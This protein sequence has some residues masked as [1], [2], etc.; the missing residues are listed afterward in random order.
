MWC[1]QPS[2]SLDRQ[3]RHFYFRL[4]PPPR[5]HPISLILLLSSSQ[6]VVLIIWAFIS[7]PLATIGAIVGRNWSGTPDNPCRVKTIARP[8][9]LKKWYLTPQVIAIMGGLLPFGSIFIE[10]YFIFTSF[11]NYKVWRRQQAGRSA[12]DVACTA[13]HSLTAWGMATGNS[14]FGLVRG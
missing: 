11:W 7:L 2:T 1:I 12:N 5:L 8:I 3:S 4:T 14:A 6:L 9:P 10:M 13:W